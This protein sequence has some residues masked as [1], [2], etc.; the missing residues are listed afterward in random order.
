MIITDLDDTLLRSDKT[1][2]DFTVGVLKKCRAAGLK[3]VFATARSTQASVAFCARFM[4]DIFVG[5]GGALV[6]AGDE[7]IHRFDIPPDIANGIIKMCL[8]TPEITGI[9]AINE[10]VALSNN[11]E[12]DMRHYQYTDF[13]HEKTNS[14]LKISLNA[15]DPVAVENIASHFP[16]CDMLRYTGEDLYRFANREAVKWNAVKAI[17][18][19]YNI[20]TD[21]FVA[22]G[23]DVNDVE[24]VAKCGVGVAVNNAIDGV[25][26]VARYIC[27]SNNDDGVALWLEEH[28]LPQSG[29]K[30]D[31][32]E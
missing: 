16:M 23:D 26:A 7:V 28:I 11:A 20:G 13:I 1:I 8:E 3:V 9:H 22:F 31:E 21:T 15:T 25:K 18:D 5:Y 12:P 19:H 32:H 6:L 27:G 4:P 2:S 24:M 10:S 14:Y 30:S 29:G 17:A